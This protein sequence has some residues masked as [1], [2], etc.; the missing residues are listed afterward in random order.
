MDKRGE[1]DGPMQTRHS[2]PSD[3]VESKSDRRSVRDAAMRFRRAAMRTD[4]PTAATNADSADAF[5]P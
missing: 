5:G 2:E 3:Y 1:Y 4:A